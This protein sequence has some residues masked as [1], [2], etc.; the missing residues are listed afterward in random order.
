M[1]KKKIQPK[2]E[3]SRPGRSAMM[4]GVLNHYSE[5]PFTTYNYKQIAHVLGAKDKAAKNLVR[6]II[7]ELADSGEL[8]KYRRGKF[9]INPEKIHEYTGDKSYITGTVDMKQTGKAYIISKEL[10]EDVFIAANNTGRALHKDIVK[11]YLFPRRKGRKLEGQI[12]EI[13]KRKKSHFVGT[14]KKSG[15]FTFLIPDNSSVPVDI[16]I[17]VSDLK[18][19]KNGQKAIVKF[20]EWPEHSK[21]PIGEVEQILGYPGNNE[22]EMQSILADHDFPLHFPEKVLQEAAKIKNEVPKRE[23]SKRR[24]FREIL[25]FTI[26]PADAKDFDDAISFRELPNG[27]F[28]V[29]IHIADVSFYVKRGSAADREAFERGTS[30]YLVDRVIPMLPEQLSN[31]VCSLRPNEEKLCF[32][33]VFEMDENAKILKEWFGKTVIRSNK[34][35]NYGK[36]QKIIETNKGDFAK[37]IAILNSLASKLREARYKK[38]SFN[39]H[40]QEVKF[41]LD[42]N[43]KPTGVYIKESKEANWLIE[44]FMLLANRKVAERI[45]RKRGNNPVKTFVYRIHDQPTPEKLSTFIQFVGK[46]GYKM[47]VSSQKSLAKSFNELF[48]EI[49]GKGEENLIETL[50]IRTMAKAVYSTNNI[51]HYGLSFPYYSHFTSPIRR[52]PDL[53]VHRLL[54]RYL[55]K[56]PSVSAEEY[57]TK[58]EHCSEMERKAEDAERAS[59]KYKQAEYLSDKIGHEFDGLISGVSKYG[60]FVEILGNKCEGMIRLANLKDDFYYLDEEN[61]RV[62]GQRHGQIYG[63]GDT[64]RIR[65]KSINLQKKQIDY[66]PAG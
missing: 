48:T 59:V 11:V 14:I 41:H 64:I 66:E 16:L 24:D 57:E 32:S 28:E 25:T 30:I 65:V 23:I 37:E 2:G 10:G 15:R 38:G 19:A 1:P 58:C 61:Y 13:L 49:H 52:Y 29:G 6:E 44:D 31:L 42:K 8:I 54:E 27:I 51:G 63:L 20:T 50:A 5:N 36:A 34:R 60:I 47:R 9:K 53:I 3:K 33:A 40:T 45:G 46:L 39:F 7:M 12:I 62:I 17:P 18:N 26:D 43:G 55:D 21:N 56:K 4:A 35:F 22:V